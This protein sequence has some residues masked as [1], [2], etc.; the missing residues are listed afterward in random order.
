[1]WGNFGIAWTAGVSCFL[2]GHSVHQSCAC[3][4]LT[5]T[6]HGPPLV[7]GQLEPSSPMLA[8]ILIKGEQKDNTNK[9][10]VVGAWR[11]RHFLKCFTGITSMK[12]MIDYNAASHAEF[13]FS[14]GALPAWHK[15]KVVSWD[16]YNA[17]HDQFSCLYKA[18]DLKWVKVT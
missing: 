1:M 5:L 9:T 12:A 8:I 4:W 7:P 15:M 3:H 10:H 13:N 17:H 6:S 14:A 2:H 16:S 11:H 18:A